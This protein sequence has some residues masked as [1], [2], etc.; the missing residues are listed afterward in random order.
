MFLKSFRLLLFPF[1][2]LYSLVAAI[3]NLMYDRGILPTTHFNV[4]LICVGNLSVGG[5]GKSPMVEY[6]LTHLSTQKKVATLSRGYRRR[7]RGYVLADA[8]TTALEIGDEPMQFHSKFPEV[9]VSVGEKRIEAVPQLLFD[10]PETEVII[11]D[12]AFQHRSISAGLNILLTDHANLYTRDFFLPAGDLRDSRKHARQADVIII[13]KC[14]V[15]L[16]TQQAAD[17]RREINPEPHQSVFFTSIVYDEPYKARDLTRCPLT[18]DMEV[19]L[20]CGIANPE[21]LKRWLEKKVA[22]YELMKFRDHHIFNLDDL[23]E[24]NRHF[25][26]LSSPNRIILT[27][28]KDFVRLEK[29]GRELDVLPILVLPIRVGFLFDE[30]VAFKRIIDNF[31]DRYADTKVRTTED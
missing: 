15:D 9:A 20:I 18:S 14:P 8:R 22:G 26:A 2:L 11:L 13:T 31:I 5:T 30:E 25:Q 24:I 21:P 3:R 7:T 12:D 10:R 1:S 17:I 19:L 4:P 23:R 16:S 6:L 27:T 28:E 29:F